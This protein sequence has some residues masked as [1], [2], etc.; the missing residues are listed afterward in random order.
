MNLVPDNAILQKLIPFV[1]SDKE[2]GNKYVQ[3][4][5]VTQEHGVSY[6]NY[7]GG[8]FALNDSL[9]MNTQS[10][11]VRGNQMLLRSAISYDVASKSST[12]KKAFAKGT[13][14]LVENMAETMAQRLEVAML[15]GQSA[16]GLATVDTG[17]VIS[18]AVLCT[19]SDATWAPGIWAGKE[20]ARV[21]VKDASGNVFGPFK[22]DA[23]DFD[24]KTISLKAATETNGQDAGSG[25]LTD[26]DGL[27]AITLYYFGSIN[28]SGGASREMIGLDKLITTSGSLFNIDNSTYALWKGNVYTMTGS[29]QL[30]LQI[31]L[32]ALGKPIAKGLNEDVVVLVHPDTWSDLASEINDLRSFDQSYDSNKGENGVKSIVYKSQ[33]GMIE[34][35]S[36]PCVKAG[37][38]FIIPPKRFK[39]IGSID[40]S[41]ESPV[42][43]GEIFL[44]LPNSAGFELRAYTDQA[45]FPEAVAKCLKITGFVNKVDDT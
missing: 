34:V 17:S 42:N 20:G 9:S 39:R 4:V 36:H 38:C 15:Y 10:A 2:T 27:T 43:K 16:T 3:N 28:V 5:I 1:S 24:A 12:N 25:T 8:A 40:I 26:I 19:V 6:A 7:D 41:F 18:S 37:D 13:S 30:T 21:A 45:L 22:I 31:I 11:E 44:H 23:L 35:I 14:M 29:D 32:Q 33:N